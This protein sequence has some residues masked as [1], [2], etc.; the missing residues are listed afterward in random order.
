MPRLPAHHTREA[1]AG[2]VIEPL[3][4]KFVQLGGSAVV[5][6]L[7]EVIHHAMVNHPRS[8]QKKIG[9]S[10]VGISC[11]RRIGY[12]LLEFEEPEQENWMA[13]IGTAVHAWLEENF[14]D[15]NGKRAT[16]LGGQQRWYTETRLTVGFVPALGFIEGSC[17]LYDRITG[18]VIDWKVVGSARLRDYRSNGPS[19]QYRSQ[20]AL[21]GQG[22]INRGLPVSQVAIVFLPRGGSLRDA[23]VW[24]D[25]F[26]PELAQAAL[27]RLSRIAQECGASG[28][29]ALAHLPTSDSF[30]SHCP[31]FSP[32]STDLTTACPGHPTSTAATPP[33][34]ALTFTA[35]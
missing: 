14:Q 9:P 4:P 27:E 8:L 15:D 13:T 26:R 2:S 10:E 28:V 35:A 21:Y 18:T 19:A 33:Q 23:Y 34:S 6:E 12:K 20:A 1:G 7:F 29:G 17:D 11:E 30:C 25:D 22:W 16:T 32:N 3:D 5:D 31:F 24:R